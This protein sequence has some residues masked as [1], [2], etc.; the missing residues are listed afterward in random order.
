MQK[1][2][3]SVANYFEKWI[4][5]INAEEIAYDAETEQ[6]LNRLYYKSPKV[7]KLFMISCK[8]KGFGMIMTLRKQIYADYIHYDSLDT[9]KEN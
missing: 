3:E 1:T 9:I 6:G 8:P 2:K 5:A 4:R 7:Y